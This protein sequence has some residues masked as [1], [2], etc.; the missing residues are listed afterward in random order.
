MTGSDRVRPNRSGGVSWR[1]V[2][3]AYAI[4]LALASLSFYI[5]IVRYRV[6][7]VTSGVPAVAPVVVL[8]MLRLRV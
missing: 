2:V 4:L 6:A 1:A 7:D 3:L 8:G 5:E